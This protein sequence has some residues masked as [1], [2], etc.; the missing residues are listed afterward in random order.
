MP[1][2]TTTAAVAE[3]IVN[4]KGNGV[5]AAPH[6]EM[7]EIWQVE[8]G[9]LTELLI[10]QMTDDM[11]AYEYDRDYCSEQLKKE[12]SLSGQEVRSLRI[13]MLDLGHHIRATKHKLDLLKHFS[14]Y[15]QEESVPTLINSINAISSFSPINGATNRLSINNAA[16]APP[17]VSLIHQAT[18][19]S[20]PVLGKRGRKSDVIESAGHSGAPLVKKGKHATIKLSDFDEDS[21]TTVQRLGFWK[22]RLCTSPKYLA[23]PPGRQPSAPCKWPLRDIAKMMVHFSV[24]HQEHTARERCMELGDALNSNRGPFEYWL[25]HS[26]SMDLGD[27]T[28]IEKVIAQLQTGSLPLILRRLSKAASQFPEEDEEE[29]LEIEE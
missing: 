27:G 26:R 4:G 25:R 6:A 29:D 9:S 17:D 14:K 3:S 11:N 8:R 16:A 23:S 5:F 2:A 10:Q 19:M 15:R 18:A 20:T 24:M 1:A 13:R 7:E 12:D 28:I 22:C 21:G